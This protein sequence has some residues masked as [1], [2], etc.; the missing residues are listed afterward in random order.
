MFTFNAQIVCKEFKNED[1]L[2]DLMNKML[3][4]PQLEEMKQE[5]SREDIYF[6]PKDA[7]HTLCFDISAILIK[8]MDIN[9]QEQFI[10]M[11]KDSI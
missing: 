2:P 10:Q 6:Q 7:V 3:N 9:D 11:R 5:L 1:I 8:K 4:V